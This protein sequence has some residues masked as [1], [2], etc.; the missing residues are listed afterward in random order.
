M[1]PDCPST[2]SAVQQ[3]FAL[4]LVL[5]GVVLFIAGWLAGQTK[6]IIKR[7]ETT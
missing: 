6:L 5:G 4:G 7:K 2:L 3:A 1:I